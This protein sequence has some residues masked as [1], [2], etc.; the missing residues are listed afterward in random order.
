MLP[1]T[2]NRRIVDA[3]VLAGLFPSIL[4]M[5]A[6]LRNQASVLDVGC[7]K[8][9]PLR[10]VSFA[11]TKTGIDG[12]EPDIAESKR[13]QIHDRYIVADL[14]QL[15]I[16]AAYADAVVCFEVI[17]HFEKPDAQA[18]LSSLD[19]V[20]TKLIIVTTPNGFIAQE[21]ADDNLFQKHLCGFSVAEMRAAGYE[22]RGMYG[23]RSLRGHLGRIEGK[24]WLFFWSLSKLSEAYVWRNPQHAFGLFCY[25]RLQPTS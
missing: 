25:K 1:P 6:L 17:E 10:F 7:G 5:R 9:S 19:A 2:L 20:A 3:V 4:K 13:L 23:L 15:A 8:R 24:P 16:P 21:P 14:T 11:G 22:V 18:L 12:Y